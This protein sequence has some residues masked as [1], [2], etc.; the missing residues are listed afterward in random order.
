MLRVRPSN[1]EL[2]TV[3][4][5]SN[6]DEAVELKA[7]WPHATGMYRFVCSVSIVCE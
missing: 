2:S 3:R 4:L 1:F 6:D 5:P 7:L